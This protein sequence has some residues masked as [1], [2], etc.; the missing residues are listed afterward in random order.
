MTLARLAVG[1]LWPYPL[2]GDGLQIL[3]DPGDEGLQITLVAGIDKPTP[4]ELAA[5]RGGPIKLGILPHSPL[6]WVVLS[7][8]RLGLDAPYAIG[9]HDAARVAALR[10]SARQAAQ[11]PPGH[12]GLVTVAT[13]DAATTKTRVL[14]AVTLSQAWHLA[15]S[16]ALEAVPSQITGAQHQRAIDAAYAQ[17]RRPEDMLLACSIVEQAGRV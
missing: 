8:E 6:V 16:K 11:W 3:L 10:E 2:A 9:V 7:A 4:K 12:R 1:E 5:M 13:V 17:Y 15:L 14:R